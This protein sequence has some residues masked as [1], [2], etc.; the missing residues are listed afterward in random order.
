MSYVYFI[1][2]IGTGRVKIGITRKDPAKRLE[3]MQTGSPYPLEVYGYIETTKPLLLEKKLHK[4]FKPQRKHGEWFELSRA[5]VEET[6]RE[7]GVELSPDFVEIS[8]DNGAVL[9]FYP[10]TGQ[11]HIPL[12]TLSQV[13]GNHA[14]LLY[15]PAVE[16]VSS[17]YGPL[18][19]YD[20]LVK[21]WPEIASDLREHKQFLIEKA[22]EASPLDW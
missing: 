2:A 16:V 6:L 13:M 9:L 22:G 11:M 8:K 4:R 3:S 20:T 15:W 12:S 1:H 5:T 7:H 14:A 19:D 21:D 17:Q 18:I 10:S